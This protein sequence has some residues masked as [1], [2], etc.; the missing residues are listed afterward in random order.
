MLHKTFWK[1]ISKACCK[2]DFK[3]FLKSG[4]K[5]NCEIKWVLAVKYFPERIPL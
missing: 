3:T 2:T 4:L 5:S 1:N